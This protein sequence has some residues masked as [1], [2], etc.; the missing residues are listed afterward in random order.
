VDGTYCS[1]DTDFKVFTFANNINRP[2]FTV[3]L[4][5]A[6]TVAG[7]GSIDLAIWINGVARFSIVAPAGAFADTNSIAG[8]IMRQGDTIEVKYTS[9]LAT[10]TLTLLELE[11]ISEQIL[12]YPLKR[13]NYDAITGLINSSTAFNI[14]DLTPKRMLL[15]HGNYLRSTLWNL[16]PDGLTFQTLD[17]NQALSTTLAGV[18]YTENANVPISSLDAPLFYGLQFE[19]KTKVPLNFADVM[20]GAAN[21]HIRFTYNGKTF[22]GFPLEITQKPA[23]NESQEWKL[24]CSPLTNVNDLVDLDIDGLN[25]LQLMPNDSFISHLCPVKFVPLDQ[26][27]DPQYHFIHMDNDWFINQV[28]FWIHKQ[29]YF[30]P[31]QFNDEIRIQ[32]IT[33]G[34]GPAQVDVYNCNA[35]LISST[36]MNV[37]TTSALNSPKILYELPVSLAGLSSIGEGVYYLVI[38]INGTAVYITEGLWVKQNWSMTL[39]LAYKHAKNKQSMIFSTGYNPVIRVHGWIDEFKPGAKFAVYE[40]QPADLEMLNGIPF[41]THKLNIAAAQGVPDWMPDKVNR[42]MLLD[43][44]LIDGKQYTR[45]GDAEWEVKNTEGWPRRYWSLGI[46]PAQNRDGITV[47]G[48]GIDVNVAVEYFLN[49]NAFGNDPGQNIISITEQD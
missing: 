30:H 9:V 20:N 45:D 6:G 34:I 29:N 3:K 14:E 8:I 19:F 49:A 25:F 31:W 7:S 12:V 46:R 42:I 22:Y 1:N 17:R 21:G 23:I 32:L 10:A 33:G 39:L 38:K 5:A 47:T 27:L 28:Q 36:A 37:I 40:D 24:L 26:V 2:Q 4:T 18:T 41:R 43:T 15:K 13:V 16:I 11:L 48:A 35:K 44:T